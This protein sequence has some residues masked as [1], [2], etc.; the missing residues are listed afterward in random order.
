M[1]KSI[2]LM[3]VLLSFF[4]LCQAGNLFAWTLQQAPMM[5]R[6]ADLES[7]AIQIEVWDVY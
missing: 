2:R 3:A 4:I 1:K 6:W 7:L 5:T